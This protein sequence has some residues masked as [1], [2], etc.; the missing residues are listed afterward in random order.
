MQKIFVG[1]YDRGKHVLSG[2]LAAMALSALL[3]GCQQTITEAKKNE[4]EYAAE[5]ENTD[6]SFYDSPY[7][8][9]EKR[10]DGTYDFYIYAS[11]VQ[12]EDDGR[13]QRIDNH[14]KESERE[15]Y[16]YEN[17]KNQIKTYFPVD[18]SSGFRIEK[19][20]KFFYLKI[21]QINGSGR[22]EI[23]QSIYGQEK[24]GVCYPLKSG[25]FLY[26]YPVYAGIH[27]EYVFPKGIP[28]DA[29]LSMEIEKQ[30]LVTSAISDEYMQF[31]QNDMGLF[32]YQPFFKTESKEEIEQLHIWEL[33]KSKKNDLIKI[34]PAELPEDSGGKT[35][36]EFSLLWDVEAMPDSTIYE[37]KAGNIF[38][39]RSAIVGQGRE[40]GTGLHYLRYRFIY[41]YQISQ[42]DIIEAEYCVKNL[43]GKLN[44]GKPELHG[45]LNQWSSTQLQWEEKAACGTEC[46]NSK[47]NLS[48]DGWYHFDITDL[49]KTAVAD[50]SGMTESLGSII[51]C[52]K[53][54]AFLATS[55]NGEFIPYIK[56]HLKKPPEGFISHESINE[57]D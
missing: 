45:P 12:Y 56:M 48:E 51:L 28:E 22:K 49:A 53:G 30:R 57:V 16:G 8:Y 47:V 34:T 5:G 11:P 32:L 38:S 6:I 52:E 55:D 39:A 1:V 24:E 3:S 44:T 35:H 15:G 21:P 41:F 26:A 54:H 40:T 23:F 9:G 33:E 20:N 36:L 19:G 46:Q 50:S 14:V 4:I 37:K 25:G 27:F 10:E 43:N 7:T 29:N 17:L 18:E 13:Y 31:R 2:I 42:K